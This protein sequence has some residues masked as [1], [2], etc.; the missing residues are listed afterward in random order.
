MSRPWCNSRSI[1]GGWDDV[2]RRF[3]R[4]IRLGQGRRKETWDQRLRPL[5]T[6]ALPHVERATRVVLVPNAMLLPLPWSVVAARAGWRSISG[7][8]MPLITLQAAG[9]LPRL[10]RRA[11]YSGESALV[12]GNPTGGL[13]HA[14]KEAREVAELL[15]VKPLGADATVSAVRKRLINSSIV[16]FAAH[17]R[18]V[19][20]SPLD[21]GVELA[22]GVLTAR[23]M[24]QHSTPVDLLVLSAC[25]TGVAESLGGDELAGL[26]QAFLLAGARSLVVSLWKVDDP[27]T[28]RMM[29][30]FYARL[31]DSADKAAALSHAAAHV[32][33]WSGTDSAYL[34]GGFIMTG[35][36]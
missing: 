35:E 16:H 23:E 36:W 14:D 17:A 31:R 21:S 10:R 3:D 2:L 20:G 5:F 1:E 8:L 12:V 25:E 22:D 13:P 7:G 26:T 32:R 24:L 18:F 4:E 30:E 34:W 29:P 27:S 28:S 11:T 19:R 33:D 9:L 15:R 6:E